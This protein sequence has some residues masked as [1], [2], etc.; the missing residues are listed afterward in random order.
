MANLIDGAPAG[1]DAER[2]T[3][4]LARPGARI[5]R[6]VSMGQATPPG[7]WLDQ[8]WDEWVLLVDGAARLAIEGEGEFPLARGD[9]VLIPAHA[10][11]RVEWT[12]PLRAT[13]WL[14]VHCGQD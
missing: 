1:H 10:R 6:I 2:F 13:I 8:A 5:E 14:A 4:L 3:E 12:D 11:H 7:E 9:Y